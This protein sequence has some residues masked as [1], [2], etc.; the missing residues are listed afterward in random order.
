V[1]KDVYVETNC[2]WFSE[3][4]ACYLACGLPVVVEDTGFSESL[5]TGDGILPFR[6]IDDA[7]AAINDVEANYQRHAKAARAIA[8]E[9][10]N[11]DKVLTSLIQEVFGGD[12]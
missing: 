10:F 12:G 9:Y 3:R 2:G 4:S 6:T 7:A 11:S 8:E 1:A 5:P